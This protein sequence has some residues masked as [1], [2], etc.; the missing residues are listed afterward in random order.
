M[1]TKLDQYKGKEF[2][3][4]ALCD[5]ARDLLLAAGIE[6][7]DNRVSAYPDKRAVRYYQ[8]L[9]LLNKPLRY[10]GRRAIYGIEHLFRATCIKLLQAE[11]HSLAQIQSVIPNAR[12]E[13]LESALREALSLPPS[14]DTINEDP[15]PADKVFITVEIAPGVIVTLDPS[16]V[17]TPDLILAR[18]KAALKNGGTQ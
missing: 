15:E 8:S 10:D 7:G 17:E 4:P 5:A 11:G 12:I 2:E 14:P 6:P 9:G 1:E 3:L 16:Q 18:I 13:Q